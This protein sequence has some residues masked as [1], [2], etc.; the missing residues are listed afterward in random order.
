MALSV[1]MWADIKTS[2][3]QILSLVTNAW[4]GEDGAKRLVKERILS[5]ALDPPMAEGDR[6]GVRDKGSEVNEGDDLEGVTGGSGQ[7]GKWVRG[8][9]SEAGSWKW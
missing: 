3:R 6:G 8:W 7:W 4:A 9:L 1:I 5:G 2:F